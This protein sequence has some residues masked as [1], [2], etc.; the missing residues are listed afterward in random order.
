[1]RFGKAA[2][3]LIASGVL[4][5]PVKSHAQTE[6]PIVIVCAW[7]PASQSVVTLDLAGKTVSDEA[8]QAN[9]G[10]S[11][12]TSVHAGTITQVT[13]QQIDWVERDGT[14][15]YSLNR[16]TLDLHLA[17]TTGGASDASC[18]KQEKQL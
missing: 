2:A 8:R 13:P 14:F 7:S 1:M 3:L 11:P 12:F 17:A 9:P 5:G 18:R 15:M 4:F 10:G 16:F 6:G